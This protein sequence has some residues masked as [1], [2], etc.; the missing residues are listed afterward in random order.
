[1]V[2]QGGKVITVTTLLLGMDRKGSALIKGSK[3]I[4]C[5]AIAKHIHIMS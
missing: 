2:L 4:K 5:K 1:M 3:L